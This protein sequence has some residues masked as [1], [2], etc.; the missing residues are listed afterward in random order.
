[1]ASCRYDLQTMPDNRLLITLCTYNERE[2]LP[3]L[4]PEIHQH[5]P[6]AD[7]LVV[8]DHSPD[9]TGELADEMAIRSTHPC[10][11][12]DQESKDWGPRFWR[13]SRMRL[14]TIIPLCSI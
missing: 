1:M 3:L 5:A 9:G 2:N 7:V 6:T 12:I 13:A 10:H 14:N 11:R 4:I 8:D